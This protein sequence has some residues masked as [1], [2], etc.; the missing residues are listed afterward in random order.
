[1]LLLS[2]NRRDRT[3]EDKRTKLT[4]AEKFLMVWVTVARMS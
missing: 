3:M 2:K 4:M 1:M